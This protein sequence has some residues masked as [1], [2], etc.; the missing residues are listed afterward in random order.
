[1]I[2]LHTVQANPQVISTDRHVLQGWVELSQVKWDAA[3][4]QLSGTAKLI[5]GEAF[6]LVIANNGLTPVKAEAQGATAKLG[7]A[8]DP[9]LSAV[10]LERAENGETAWKISYK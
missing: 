7:A 1:M 3:A 10:I 4:K 6:K 5:G 8:N 2:S 9:S